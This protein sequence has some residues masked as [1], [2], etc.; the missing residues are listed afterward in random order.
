MYKYLF[1]TSTFY[2][3]TFFLD[4]RSLAPLTINWQQLKLCYKDKC[5]KNVRDWRINY[6]PKN[7]SW[8]YQE[9][10]KDLDTVHILKLPQQN[11]TIMKFLQNA[12]EANMKKTENHKAEYLEF[13][14]VHST[15]NSVR[16]PIAIL[17]NWFT[18]I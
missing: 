11:D 9:W 5:Q 10:G 2:Y 6:W 15:L 18:D 1:T 17:F 7:Y 16:Y 14:R 13:S 4:E 8:D 12:F 3:V